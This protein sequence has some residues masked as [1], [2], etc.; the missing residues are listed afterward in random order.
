MDDKVLI[1]VVNLYSNNK[2]I[3]GEYDYLAVVCSVQG[4]I[5]VQFLKRQDANKL[6]NKDAKIPYIRPF[7][8]VI[9]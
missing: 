4:F 5:K 6:L 8:S 1:K 3:L 7:F 2:D 9:P